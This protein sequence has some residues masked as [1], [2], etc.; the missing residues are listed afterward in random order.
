MSE[1]NRV[2][3][4]QRVTGV[5]IATLAQQ[6]TLRVVAAGTAEFR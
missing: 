6:E 5:P 1:S 4:D 3:Y 2:G